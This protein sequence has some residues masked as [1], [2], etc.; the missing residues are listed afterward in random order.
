V[1]AR[2]LQ[3][4]YPSKIFACY[5]FGTRPVEIEKEMTAASIGR[6]EKMRRAMFMESTGG[7]EQAA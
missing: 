5:R 3:S 1:H 6:G 4:L 2:K 7:A